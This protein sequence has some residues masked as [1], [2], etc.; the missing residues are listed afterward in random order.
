MPSNSLCHAAAWHTWTFPHLQAKDPSFFRSQAAFI[1]FLPLL[2][3][4]ISSILH[5]LQASPFMVHYIH[6]LILLSLQYVGHH[7]H[8]YALTFSTYF[9]S[10]CLSLTVSTPPEFSP[11]HS[12]LFL[13]YSFFAEKKMGFF[14]KRHSLSH[15]VI[16]FTLLFYNGTGLL[17]ALLFLNIR[18]NKPF[19][20]SQ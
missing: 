16:H 11:N 14:N 2:L 6:W 1:C 3:R 18:G 4:K 5:S 10:G 19:L 13:F 20:S 9:L 15:P 17:P 12:V 8:L 7:P